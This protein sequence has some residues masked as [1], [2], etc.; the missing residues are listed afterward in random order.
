[1]NELVEPLK[2]DALGSEVHRQQSAADVH[3][4]DSGNDAVSDCH[5][6][7]YDGAFAAMNIRHHADTAV[8][9]GGACAKC[10]EKAVGGNIDGC[11]VD[12]CGV[13]FGGDGEHICVLS[14]VFIFR[15]AHFRGDV[16]RYN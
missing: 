12:M 4:N 8:F 6:Q 16:K 9:G 14:V 1:M 11:G 7:S 2:V 15:I 5:G 10:A 13:G 3:A